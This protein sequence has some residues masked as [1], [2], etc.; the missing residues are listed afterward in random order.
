MVQTVCKL[1]HSN[2]DD[3]AE[4]FR[5]GG[6]M[7]VQRGGVEEVQKQVFIQRL[8]GKGLVGWEGTFNIGVYSVKSR[9]GSEP[10]AE[11]PNKEK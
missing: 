9:K 7:Y 8:L 10:Q 3:K 6:L 11:S 1:S 2:V 4:T 5:E